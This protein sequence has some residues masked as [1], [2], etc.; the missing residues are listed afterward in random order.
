MQSYF[1]KCQ[2]QR[3]LYYL[4][5]YKYLAFIYYKL[6][7]IIRFRIELL[8]L[9]ALSVAFIFHRFFSILI[10]T[11]LSITTSSF[12]LTIKILVKDL[13]KSKV[14]ATIAKMK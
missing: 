12:S 3:L 2:T 4:L 8:A 6:E 7:D 10:F 5:D 13:Y 11:S 14:V 9:I 1:I